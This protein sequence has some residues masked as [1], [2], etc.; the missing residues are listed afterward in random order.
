MATV[1]FRV[2]VVGAFLPLAAGC[3]SSEEWAGW[4]QH[5]AHFASGDHLAFSSRNRDLKTFRITDGD[6]A[7]ASRQAWWGAPIPQAPLADVAGH[8]VGL[9]SGLGVMSLPRT[10]TAVADF[11]QAGLS[12]HGRVVLNDTGAAEVPMA[13]SLAGAAGVPVT[14]DVNGPD[15]VVRH[16]AGAQHFLAVLR[17]TG[18]RMEGHVPGSAGPLRI[19]LNR[20]KR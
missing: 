18:D 19:V 3:A 20:E 7:A 2:L 6:V 5:P 1:R 4:R 15:V 16:E 12:G 17:V 10:S 9:W 13:V 11:T 8:W 14:V